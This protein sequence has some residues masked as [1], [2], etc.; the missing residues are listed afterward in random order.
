MKSYSFAVI[1]VL[2]AAAFA[3]AEKKNPAPKPSKSPDKVIASV[4]NKKLTRGELEFIKE[5]LLPAADDN[6]IL[7]IW[8]V[9]AV[10]AGKAR[11]IGMDKLPHIHS[12]MGLASDQVLAALYI[13]KLQKDVSVS[14][15]ETKEFYEKNKDKFR[16]LPYVS[17]KMIAA[18]N[19]ADIEKIKKKLIDG[20]KFDDLFAKYK[21]ETKKITGMSTAEVKG[22]SARLL[23][24][25]LGPR[26]VY[27]MARWQNFK[28]VVGPR[29]IA[30][31]WILFKM[32]GRKPGE[33]VA[34]DKIASKLKAELERKKKA[35]IRKKI[36]MDAEKIAGVS[37]PTAMKR[38]PVVVRKAKPS[39]KSSAGKK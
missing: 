12:V 27:T 24:K 1:L 38:A 26:V 2:L 3:Q 19:R 28:E 35:A 6:R 34:F 18:E 22:M 39:A 11:K 15:K 30:R 25:N 29:R 5:N 9:D 17:A 10:L 36:I 7:Y 33:L 8:K 37:Q 31:G 32:T 13:N 4:G 14:D 20:A 21:D 16:D 23:M